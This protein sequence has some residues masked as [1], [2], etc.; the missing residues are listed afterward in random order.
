M[1]IYSQRVRNAVVVATALMLP[2][3]AVAH[4]FFLL[5]PDIMASGDTTTIKATIGSYFPKPEIAIAAD[6]VDALRA[7]GPGAPQLTVASADTDGLT[8]GVSGAKAGTLVASASI[9]ARDVD[10]AEDRIPLILGEYRIAPAA[11]AAIEG[12]AKPRTLRVVSRRLAKTVACIE[13]CSGFA[14]AMLPIDGSFEFVAADEA[15]TRYRLLFN[16]QPLVGH[17]VDMVSPDGKRS[18]LQTDAKGEI[19]GPAMRSGQHMIFA[20]HMTPPEAG[21]RYILDLTSLTAEA[22]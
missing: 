10:Y 7:R 9:K 15:G 12:M 18:E 20:A 17:P 14:V 13:R 2:Q 6:R 22:R 8:L 3:V 11:R 16:G 1:K 21:G 19:A 4:D 5:A